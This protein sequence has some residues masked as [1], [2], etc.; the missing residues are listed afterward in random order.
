MTSV[1][2][3]DFRDSDLSAISNNAFTG[4][5]GLVTLNLAWNRITADGLPSGC[6]AG[7]TRLR[8]LYLHENALQSLP[9]DF[10]VGLT[11]LDKLTLLGAP[12]LS[13]FLVLFVFALLF[14][15]AHLGQLQRFLTM[16]L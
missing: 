2:E 11:Q 3:L 8:N 4:M 16:Y 7:L 13:C 14:L 1:T 9:I 5:A 12:Q 15:L 6:F 10:L